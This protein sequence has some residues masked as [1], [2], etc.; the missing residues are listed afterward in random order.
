MAPSLRELFD[1]AITCHRAGELEAASRGYE[2]ILA[3]HPEHP[4]AL[5][6]LATVA[7]EQQR[8]PAAAALLRRAIAVSG[9]VAQFHCHLGNALQG[10]GDP[11]GAEDAYRRAV[12]LDPRHM[13]ALNNLGFALLRR[14]ALEEAIECLRGA[15]A[16][17]PHSPYV[18]N[19]LGDALWRSGD[20]RAAAEAYRRAVAA[21]PAAT[22]LRAKLG[23]VLRSLGRLD[24]ALESLWPAVDAGGADARI[25]R[26]IGSL[27]R[28]CAPARYDA[29]LEHRVLELIAAPDVDPQDAA[30][31]AA[32]L[33][34]LKYA[35]DPRFRE[36]SDPD[37]VLDTFLA[38]ALVRALLTR[39]VNR[40][41]G[42]ESLLVSA[43]RSL[44]LG[45]R[46]ARANGRDA[47]SVLAQQ[48]FNNEY[49][50]FVADDE[51]ARLDALRAELETRV[52][53]SVPPDARVERSL[54]LYALYSPLVELSVADRLASRP[55]REWSG[56]LRPLIER[57]LLEPLEEAALQAGI[58][59]LG[60]IDN[61]V[62]RAVKAQY[63][64]NPY[65]RWLAPAY[66]D[67]GD[68]H[69]I[70]KSMFAGYEPHE[71]LKGPI[72]VLVVGCGTGHH[73]ISVALRY[74]GAEVVATDISRRSLA[75]GVRMAR[76][77]G[78]DNVRFVENDLLNLSA[79]EGE[80]HVIECV[81][82]LHHTQSI[83][84]G[85]ESLIAKLHA[86]GALKIGLYSERARAPLVAAHERIETLGLTASVDGIRRLRRDV[87]A[88]PPG[89][90]LRRI[91]EF[92]DFYTLGSCRDL[93]FH[94]HEQSVTLDALGRLLAGAGLRFIGFE[95]IDASLSDAYRR[96]FPQDDEMRDLTRWQALEEQYPEAFT[97]MY[98][99]WCEKA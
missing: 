44:L 28:V 19:N 97:G 67:A 55:P 29:R 16:V 4:D 33:V 80:F 41:A 8:Y 59:S 63:E 11:Q 26:L 62:S 7:M 81:G 91:L 18:L 17:D 1:S 24:E 90:P 37:F 22:E 92:G 36:A 56:A 15:L 42:I 64:T 25:L 82:V 21:Q 30:E 34:R 84:E 75:Y 2:R 89:D 43:R 71:V 83:G 53:W 60:A 99:F 98:Q 76:R 70:L 31:F 85:L 95:T 3:A 6:L 12:A 5:N 35:G 61:P 23:R 78:V 88:A 39:T 10:C 79:L 86:H 38:D 20:A 50:C 47:M 57:T 77:L 93:V 9:E 52:D 74:A 54:L 45:A 94:V 69:G 58:E 87:L 68:V 13:E 66:R 72:R 46:A 49:A 32:E 73:P 65:P 48:C 96:R 51:H 14:D 40:D 27:A